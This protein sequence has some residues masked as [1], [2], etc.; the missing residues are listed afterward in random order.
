MI[1]LLASAADLVQRQV[2]AIVV[3]S[4]QATLVA[5]E[6]TESI[7]IVFCTGGDPVKPGLVASLSSAGW[8]R[9]RY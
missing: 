3:T 2:S 7:P 4:G 1:E 5:K 6:A 9:Y 8:L